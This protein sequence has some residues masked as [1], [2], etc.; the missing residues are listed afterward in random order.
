MAALGALLLCRVHVL[1][2]RGAS[3]HV[4]D[5]LQPRVLAARNLLLDVVHI[6]ARVARKAE[7]VQALLDKQDVGARGAEQEHG[8]VGSHLMKS[9]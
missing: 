5:V 7:A 8:D 3:E 6:R 2:G 4:V 9:R 1:P